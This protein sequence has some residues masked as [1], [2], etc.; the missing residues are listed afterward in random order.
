MDAKG[1]QNHQIG[2]P[3]ETL[4]VL[5]A[6]CFGLG[7]AP[8]AP[9][10]AGAL[11]GVAIFVAVVL[12]APLWL[13]T[14]LIALALLLFCALTVA[15]TPWAEKYW[16]KKDPGIFVT[17]EVAGFL[18]TVLLFRTPDLLL[19]V[20]WAFVVTRILDIIKPPP[21]RQLE[22]LP[23]GWGVLLDDIC[24]SLMAVVLLHIAAASS[25]EW[26]GMAA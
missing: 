7:F 15:L 19:T 3:R 1:N 10:T 17:D 12:F 6:T 8:V 24:A 22:A 16:Q 26:F 11:L 9:G 2:K 14:W 18:T 5:L 25:P 13:H 21:A 23:G 4:L 20:L